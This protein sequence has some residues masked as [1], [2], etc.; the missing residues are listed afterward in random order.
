MS[1]FPDLLEKLICFCWRPPHS[2]SPPR[3][4]TVKCFYLKQFSSD[5]NLLL[6]FFPSSRR[7]RCLGFVCCIKFVS[8]SIL[9]CSLWEVQCNEQGEQV[10]NYSMEGEK[11]V[12]SRVEKNCHNCDIDWQRHGQ[13][14]S[15]H[16]DILFVHNWILKTQAPSKRSKPAV[17]T[18]TKKEETPQPAA[19]Y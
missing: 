6:E 15:C 19:L 18:R 10:K 11:F 13:H 2:Q 7:A 5:Q 14:K 12:G 9:E 8:M 17:M 3:S 1:F 16:V 4:S